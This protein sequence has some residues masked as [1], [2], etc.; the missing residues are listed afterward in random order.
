MQDVYFNN[1][2]PLI[3]PIQQNEPTDRYMPDVWFYIWFLVM[4]ALA[5]EFNRRFP[6]NFDFEQ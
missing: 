3:S 2:C 6:P 1:T 4:A 5:I